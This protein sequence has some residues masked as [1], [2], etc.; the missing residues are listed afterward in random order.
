M[1][2]IAFV[3]LAFATLAVAVPNKEPVANV[4]ARNPRSGPSD[5]CGEPGH[6]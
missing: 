1:R 2:I 5:P 6:C 4:E 3:A